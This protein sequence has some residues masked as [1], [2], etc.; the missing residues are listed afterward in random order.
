MVAVITDTMTTTTRKTFTV[1]AEAE[2]EVFSTID[3][4]K[5]FLNINDLRKLI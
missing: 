4:K 5:Q 1:V 2:E 3:E